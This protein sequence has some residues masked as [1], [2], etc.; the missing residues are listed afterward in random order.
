MTSPSDD[1]RSRL[2]ELLR[3]K[4]RPSLRVAAS[5]GQERMWLQER[6]SPGNAALHMAVTVRI[7]GQLDPVA[8]SRAFQAVV[9]RHDALRTTF[10]EH[11]GR[12]LQHVAPDLK[13]S[14]SEVDLGSLPEPLREPE[15]LRHV[16]EDVRVPFDLERGPLLRA[17]RY[18]LSAD[19]H[20]LLLTVHHIVSDGWSMGVLVREVAELYQAFTSGQAPALKPL[21]LQYADFAAWQR[22]GAQGDALDAQLSYWRQRLDPHAVLELPSDR[23]RLAS[24]DVQGA[25]HSIVLQPALTQALKELGLREGRTLFSVLLAAFNVL[26][27]RYSGLDDLAVGTPV[28]GRSRS[29]LEGLIGLFVN[30]LV[31]RSD[32]SGDPSFRE[33]LGRVHDSAL[34][35]FAHQDVPFEKL[36]EVLQPSRRLN[37]SPLFQVMFVL[38]NAPVAL[39]PVPGVRM[40]AQPVDV[41]AARFDLTLVASEEARG[42]RLIA[43]YRTALFDEAT[44][45]RMLGHLRSLLQAVVLDAG[46]RVSALPLMDEAEQRQVLLDWNDTRVDLSRTDTLPELIQA[47]VERTPDAVALAFEG[48]TLTYRELDARANQLAHALIA[49]GVGPEVRVGLLMERSLELVV[50]LLATLKAGGAYVPFDPAYPAQRLSWM[51]EDARP[52]VLLAQEHL[53]SRLP[54]HDARVLCLDTQWEDIALLPRHAPPSR[55]TADA[56]AYVIFTSGSTGR[57]KGAMNAHGPVVNRLLWMQSAYALGPADVVLQKTP[58]SF[59]VSVWE[60]FWPLMTGARLVLAKPGGHQDPAYLARLVAEAGVT[61]LHFVPSMLQVFLEEPALESCTSL[62]RV[63]CSGEALPLELAERCLRRLPWAG[64]HNLYGPTEAAVDVTFHQCLPG[65]SR[66][67]VPIGRPVANTQIRILDAHLRP[68]PVGVPGEL[69]IGGVQVGRGYLGRPELTA[70]RFIPDGFSDSPGARL[71]RTGDV[72]RWLP[73]GAIE[74]VG[75]ADFQVKVRGLR[76]ELGEIEAALEQ[77][78]GVRQSVVVAR[79]DAAGDKRLVAYVAF[80][81]DGVLDVPSLRSRLHEKLPEYMVP[82]AFVLLDSLP[83][84]PS[85]KVDRK[86]LPEPEAPASTSGYLAPRTPTEEK[87]AALWAQVLHVPRVGATDHFFELGGHSLLATQLVSR[88]RAA[89]GVELALRSVFEA[90]TVEALARHLDATATEEPAPGLAPLVPVPRGA[91][92]PLSF[93]QQR[94]WLI[95]QLEPGTAT[96]NMPVALRLSGAL[97]VESLR[98]GLEALVHRHESLRTTFRDTPEGPVQ[99]IAPPSVLTLDLTDLRSLPAEERQAEA[100]RRA[101][102]E[103]LLPFA[104]TTGPLLRATLL[105]L[106]EQEHLLLLTLHHIVS[107]GWSLGVLVREV[108]ELYRALASGQAPSLTPLRLHYADYAAWQRQWMR[109]DALDAQL[110]YWRQRLDPHAVL[111]LPSDRPRQA[112]PDGRGARYELLL[113]LPLVQR[114]KLVALREGRT[115]FSVLLAAF[116]VLLQR[117]S[118]QDDLAVGTPVAG[119]SRSELEGLIG[120]FVNTLVLRSDLSGDPS[121]RELLAQVHDS[122][123]GAF[124]HQDVPFEKLVEVLQPSRWLNVSPLFQVMFVLQ[125]AP[126]SLVPIPGLRMDTL[127]VDGGVSRFDLTLVASEDAR[128]LRLSA[129]YRTALFDEATVARMLGHLR[130]LLQS[131]VRDV[132]QPLSA[133][134]LMDEAE[135]RQLLVDWNDTRSPFPHETSIHQRFADQARAAPDAV[136]VV[137]GDDA[138]TYRQLDERANQLAHALIG[139]GVRPGTPVALGLGRSLD[140][141]VAILGVLKAGAAYVPLEMSYPHERLAMLLEDSGAPVL[142]TRSDWEQSLPSFF[143][144][145]LLMDDDAALLARKPTYAPAVPSSADSLAY[146]MFTSGSTGR[147]KGVMVPHRG[148]MRLVCGASYFHFG[149]EHR[150]FQLAPTAFDASTME[151]WSALLHGAQLVL[152]PPHSLSL[153]ELAAFFRRHAPTSVVLTTAL[154]EQMALHQG[155][156]LAR[157]SQLMI[158]GDVMPA[159][160]ARQH[161]AKL[162]P[163]S[164]LINGYGPTE[165]TTASTAHIMGP[166]SSVGHAVPI[167]KPIGQ[168]TVY[169]LDATLRPVPVGVAGELFVGGAGLAW[170]YLRRPDLTAERFVPNAFTSSPGERLYRTGDKARW[171]A[172]GTL[173]FLGRTDFQVKVRGFRIEPGEVESALQRLPGVAE[174]L[175]MAREDVPGDKRL[176]AYVAI[177]SGSGGPMLDAA[178]LRAHLQQQLPGHMVPTAFVVMEALPLTP[179]GKVDREALPVPTVAPLERGRY[180]PPTTPTEQKLAALW[181]EV[182]RVERIGAEDDFFEVGGHSLLATQVV[183]RVLGAFGVE[184]PLRTFFEAPTLAGLARRIDEAGPRA[185][186][187]EG[188]ALTPVPRT[189]DLPLSFAQQRLWLI[190]QLEPGSLAY[191][192]PTAL[193][194]QGTVDVAALEQAF[195]TLIERHEPLRTTFAPRQP[196]PVQVIHTAVDFSLPVEDLST[197]GEAALEESRRLASAEAVRPFDLT[198]G[199]LLRVQLLRLAPTEHVLLLTMHHIVSDGWSM[200]VLVRELVTFYEAFREGRSPSVAPLA[201]QYADYAVWQ[202]TWLQGEVLEAQLGYWKQQLSGAPALLELPTDKPRPAVQSQRGASVSVQLPLALSEALSDFSQREGVTPFM[203]LLA[204]FQVLLSRYSGQE[205]VSVGSPIAGRTRGE[206]E[207]L[208]GL[209]INTLV[210]RS[211]V[212]PDASFRQLLAQVRDTTLAAYEHQH[213]PFEKLVEELQPQRSLSHSPLF[214]VMLVL[215]NAPVSELSLSGLSFR[216][217]E[218]D[219]EATKSDL[220][221]SLSQSPHGLTGTLGYRTD[222]FEPSTVARMVEHLRVLLA[223]A[224]ASP[225]MLVSELPLLTDAEKQLLL[226]DF[227]STDA[228]LP[229]PRS[230]HALFEQRAALHPDAPAVASDGQMLTY[231]ELDARANQLAWHLRSLGVGTDSCVALCLE[232]SVE[233]VVALL[234]VWKAG[235]AYVPLDPAQPAL[236]LQSLVQEVGA[237]VVV[238]MTRHTSAFASSSAHVVRLDED[239]SVLSRLGTNAPPSAAHPDSLAYVLFTSGSTGRPKGVAV[240]HS[241]LSTYVSSVTQRLGLEACSS[242]ALVSTFVA[243]LGNTV[244]FP[245]LTTGGLLH[246]L[247]QECASSP[248]ALADYFAHHP[249]DCMKV[250]PSHLAALLTAPEPRHVLPRKRL[251][252]GG[253]SSTWALLQTVHA[254]APDCEVHNHYGPTE[255]TVGVLAG[256]VQLSASTSVPLGWPLA[257]SRLYVLDASLRPTPLGVPGELFVGGAQVT[258]GYLGRP[259]LT[260]ER[261][262][263]DPFSPTAGA[264]MYRT[265]D[266]VRWL[267]DGRVEFLGRVDFQVK[268]R[269]FRVEPGEVATVLRGLAGVHEA[270]VVARQDTPGE[271]RLVAYVVAD[272]SDASALRHDLKQR[273]P[274][275]MVPSAFVFLDAL[276]LTP[277]GKVDRNALPIPDVSASTSDYVAPRTPTEELLAPLWAEVLR[278]PRVGSQDHFFD[279]GG[280]SLLATQLVARVRAAF[281]VELPLRSVFEAPSLTGLARRIDD[282]GKQASGIQAPPLVP[283]PRTGELPLSF[284]QQRLWFIDQLVPGASTYNVPSILHLEGELHLEAVRRALTELVRRHEALRTRFPSHQGQPF[285]RIASPTDLPLPIVDLSS[286]GESALDEARRLA[287]AEAQRP[288]DLA[289]GPLVR[290]L[291]LKL[292]PTEHVLVFTLHHIVSDGW[293]R[294]VLVREVAAL[295]TVFSEDRPSPLRELPV[296]YADYA[297]WQRSWLQGDVLDTQLDYWRQRLADAAPLELPTDFPRPAVQSSHGAMKPLRLPLPLA[298]ALKALG[299]REGVTPFMFLLAAFQVLLSLYSGQEDI[300]VGTPIAGRTYAETESLIGFFVN[301]L[302][303]RTRVSLRNS[304]HQLLKQVRE[305]ALGAYAHQDVPFERLVEDLRPQ[306]DL[307]RPPLFQALFS[308]QNTSMTEVQL[309]GLTLRPLEVEGHTVKA[310]LELFLFETPDG[311]DGSLGYNTALFAPA[312]AQRMARHFGVLVEALVAHPEAPLASA[313]M[314]SHEEQRQVLLDW[315]DT[316]SAFPHEASIHQRFASQARETP[317]AVALIFG[318]DHL[319]YRQLDERSNQL[320]HALIDLGVTPGTPVALGLERSFDLIISLLAILKVGAAYVPL[321]LAHPRERLALLLQDCAAPL[322]LS[323]SSLTER[324]P[325]FPGRTLL[326]DDEAALLARQPTHAP[327]VPVS[328]DSLAYVLFTSGSTGQPKGVLV[329]HRGVTRLVLGSDFIR[330]GADEV[331]FH[332]AP[333]AFDASTLEIWGALLHGAKLVLAPPHALSTEELAALLRH[334]RVTTLWLTAALFEQMSL[335]QGEA[336]AQVRQVL[337]GGDVLPAERVRQHLSRLAPGSVLVNGYGPTENTTFST[338]LTLR[339]D[340]RVDGTVSIGRPI[341]NASAYVLDAQLRPVP[342]GVPGELFVG[343]DGLAWGYLHRTDLTAERFIPH[344]FATLPGQRLYRTGDKARWRSDGTLDFLGRTDFQVK[345]RGFRIEPGEIEAAL[346]RLPA[347]SEALVLLREDL[348]GD[349]RLVAYVVPSA[350]VSEALT[351]TLRTQLQQQLPGYMVPSAFV[352][353]E[354]LPLTANGK[355]DRKAL[356]APDVAATHGRYVAPRTP[357]EQLIAQAFAEV[358]RLERVSADAD[359]FDLGGHSLLAVHLMALL[360]ERTGRALPLSALFQ[361]STVERLAARLSP[362]EEAQVLGPNLARL[363]TGDSQRRPLFL[364]HGGGGGVLSYADLVRHL[365]NER[366][367]YGVFA[368]GL[369][370]G[371][372]PPN[373]MESLARLYLEQVRGV[374]PHGPYR[375]AGWSFGG[376][377]VYEMARQFQSLGEQVEFLALLD[378]IAPSGEPDPEP[379]PMIRLAA[380]GK[381]VGLPVQDVPAS[382]FEQLESLDGEALL[383]RMIHLLRNLPAAGG[384]EPGQIERLFAVHERLGEANRGYIP[385]GPYEGPVELFRAAVRANDPTRAEDEGW[386]A[387]LPGGISVCHVPGT[388]LTLLEEPQV[389]TLAEQLTKRLRALDAE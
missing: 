167:G 350:P 255:T 120:L 375:L 365:G 385:A 111:E 272:T 217:L 196:E 163:G 34:G 40:E 175:V 63:V 176:V 285:Q 262:V 252:L 124:A 324:L 301:T 177:P 299:R 79:E 114:L 48:H 342:V 319:T 197:S 11:E 359:F 188:P 84:T 283:A 19:E 244:L 17:V 235:G 212:A 240:A 97:D 378:S 135:Q 330:F 358:L 158:G 47:Q 72:A 352:A 191:N 53:L 312:T 356:P 31:L 14:I 386:K 202:R 82:S 170:G 374:Q 29:E 172:D 353:L 300:S 372:L 6:L 65:E 38:Q 30:T 18:R 49:R 266:R 155:D 232:R 259:D 381:M 338:T 75:R 269:G 157:V 366:P 119:R 286:L 241:Q 273:L 136:A 125:N 295:Y 234:A 126:L 46:Q 345:L 58:F 349:K 152:A 205:D 276:P 85:G 344:P 280:H 237:P 305:A 357:L 306:R 363:D 274:E 195:R 162:S 70:E 122:A 214:Q 216:P 71:Y 132:R 320:A 92:P 238:T 139:L 316:R 56:L 256:R 91:A 10:P 261:Y 303:L 218:R 323:H 178:A 145:S 253:E 311:F 87:L 369:E 251:V 12:P 189:E 74:Y 327:D 106:E 4:T 201:V 247:S 101:T 90:P 94:L 371:D 146:V 387:W 270:V 339:P 59:D 166:A 76:I 221:L 95:D 223:A 45:A 377:V 21:P 361:G 246:V 227:V 192:I 110:A 138:L 367:V 364:V 141:I 389:P 99:V 346:R 181:L 27:Q 148:V 55:A 242:F 207:G 334:H 15:A 115:L 153:E 307:T 109:G 341:S 179:N 293:S 51:L 68:V 335:H 36:V 194:M 215:Q 57:P 62:R 156:T 3:G 204:A 268:V 382:E 233:T 333:V 388:H 209:F 208:I 81:D 184:L 130:V 61:T 150:Y 105:V 117:Y 66:R 343:G 116:N 200:G 317:D 107:D 187:A 52:A 226:T 44:V 370:D 104:L 243:D 103:A 376:L 32:L 250:V 50:A 198:R 328:A 380:F 308:L 219:F 98:R 33:L 278:L 121:F 7:S 282:A 383:S 168:S 264:R 348:P 88:V 260:A 5:S 203:A 171:R 123:L 284:A 360:R 313:S 314:L 39:P 20:L 309:P 325:S 340:T 128:G 83:L 199:P 133:M 294:G 151:I 287:S 249:I 329:P 267:S 296:Q 230:V 165:N 43:E 28:A 80:R 379:P 245:A 336:L 298:N 354:A 137:F 113:P 220:T 112:Q 1:K 9:D 54:S 2:A 37:V 257:Y 23:P 131:V 60:F 154:F 211:H 42:L 288:F 190:D 78:P 289:S 134:P 224:I 73:D 22:Q 143:G 64:L 206:T 77:H 169:V 271:A 355:V 26:L 326:L 231:G 86:A 351:E 236:R 228:P 160:R 373:S 384:L 147:P 149:P 183:S 96:Y 67:S 164:V 222:L 254:L 8:L 248:A 100:R 275:Y 347:V 321:E 315:N 24:L 322:L 281:S 318:D 263:P 186:V 310:E 258:R 225:E 118:G 102:A 35:A 93:A 213:L 185:L 182:L 140:L 144:A 41:G 332:F 127:P 193:R 89:F 229:S 292:A 129:E 279:L 159:E 265:G 108:A 302:V 25:R 362:S 173:E 290:A 277:N 239:A 337:A 180:V 210:L 368:P 13:L 297:L 291:L 304:F 161:L 331:L 142:V 174:T 69:F 16:R